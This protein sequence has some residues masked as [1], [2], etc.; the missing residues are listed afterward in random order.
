[1]RLKAQWAITS[2]AMRVRGIKNCLSNIQLVGKK[3]R[4]KTTLASKT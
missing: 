1:M 4:D 2:E 3:S